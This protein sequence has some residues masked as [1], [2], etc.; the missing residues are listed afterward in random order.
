MLREPSFRPPNPDDGGEAGDSDES[1]GESDTEMENHG[2]DD[3]DGET[4]TEPA[5]STARETFLPMKGKLGGKG[6]GKAAASGSIAPSKLAS[7]A[8][9]EE[10]G[11][12]TSQ[13]A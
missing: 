7:S 6:K 9:P 3:S 2:Q 13:R 5:A 12:P 1:D 8:V 11:K 10:D 4:E